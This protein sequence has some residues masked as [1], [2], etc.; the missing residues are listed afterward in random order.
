MD[1]MTN[2]VE[3]WLIRGSMP[4]LSFHFQCK[5]NSE[6]KAHDDHIFGRIHRTQCPISILFENNEIRIRGAFNNSNKVLQIIIKIFGVV[7]LVTA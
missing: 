4:S 6:I 1:F 7:L 5:Y 2:K 3:K